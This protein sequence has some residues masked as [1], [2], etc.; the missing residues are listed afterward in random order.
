MPQQIT[1][2]R[3]SFYNPSRTS[4]SDLHMGNITLSDDPMIKIEQIK[5]LVI[6]A[7]SRDG[8]L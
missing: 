7:L 5:S 1:D 2:I 8:S 3:I 6:V 4:D